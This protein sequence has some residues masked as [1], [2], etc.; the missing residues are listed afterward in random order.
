MSIS[1]PVKSLSPFRISGKRLA[2]QEDEYGD[3]IVIESR[4]HLNLTFDMIYEQS[5]MLKVSPSMP[6][7]H[8]IRAMLMSLSFTPVEKVLVL[9]LGGGCLVRAINVSNDKIAQDVVEIREAVIHVAKK[10]FS[11]PDNS[12]TNYHVQDAGDFMNRKNEDKYDIIFSDLYSEDA[13]IPLQSKRSFL[14]SCSDRLNDNGWLVI[15]YH[16]PPDVYSLFSY[17]LHSIFKTVLYCTVPSGN[18]IIYARKTDLQIPLS[19]YQEWGDSVGKMFSCD[20]STL[21]RRLSFWPKPF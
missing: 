17:T 7:H 12:L 9:G 19:K 14:V 21:S 6:V 5:K 2:H 3:V 8:Y 18:T 1:D 20:V 4:T 13:M 15:N 11:L 10:Y 16:I